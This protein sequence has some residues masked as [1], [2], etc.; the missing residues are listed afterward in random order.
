MTEKTKLEELQ[1]QIR[2]MVEQLPLTVESMNKMKQIQL[3]E[4]Q[5]KELAKKALTTDT[6]VVEA[7]IDE[8]N[9]DIIKFLLG[10]I[11][12]HTNKINF[13]I[14]AN[15]S[16]I[17]GNISKFP[18]NEFKEILDNNQNLKSGKL[19]ISEQGLLKLDFLGE[20]G[21][22]STYFLVGKE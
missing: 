20:E 13:H 7:G 12:N 9:N 1:T 3:D 2:A 19:H 14:R 4:E 6:F 17:G 10:G 8:D 15:K 16:C 22:K 5:A 21:E 18:I 11:D